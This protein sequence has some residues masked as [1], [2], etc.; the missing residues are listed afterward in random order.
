MDRKA[1]EV[2]VTGRVQGVFFRAR[3]AEEADRHGV[4]GWVRNE[5]DGTVAAYFEGPP[6][7]VDAVVAWCRTGPPRA[8]VEDVRTEVVEPEGAAGFRVLG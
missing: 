1:V 5:P 3:T 7:E 4:A 2:V 8:G 6:D